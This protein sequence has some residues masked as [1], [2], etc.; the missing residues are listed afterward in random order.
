MI[1]V[2]I[3]S[4]ENRKPK[5]TNRKTVLALNLQHALAFPQVAFFKVAKRKEDHYGQWGGDEQ[6]AEGH[7]LGI[8]NASGVGDHKAAHRGNDVQEPAH[9]SA[10]DA[11][12][13]GKEHHILR[14]VIGKQK[15]GADVHD[16]GK[17]YKQ[18]EV[19]DHTS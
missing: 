1:E 4:T 15:P 3:Q 18:Y 12:V 13:S 19:I 8:G 14:K 11:C 6:V 10:G 5:T 9:K 2:S 17:T 7:I 16:K